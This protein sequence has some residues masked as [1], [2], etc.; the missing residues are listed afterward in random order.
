M[1]T[2][3][4]YNF[5]E[6]I[7]VQDIVTEAFWRLGIQP[8][9]L[10]PIDE[11]TAMMAANLELR[12]WSATH[13][14]FG[15]IQRDMLDL[16]PGQPF[17]TLS[18]YTNRVFEVTKANY[19][20]ILNG[21]TPIASQ[22]DATPCFTVGDT[23]GLTQTL[24]NGWIGYN[25][26][27]TAGLLPQAIWYVGVSALATTSYCLVIE[28]SYDNVTWFTQKSTPVTTYLAGIL[29]WFVCEQPLIAPYWRIRE[30][31]GNILAIQQIYFCTPNPNMSDL[32]L[33]PIP[34]D[35]FMK[36]TQKLLPNNG[37]S[38]YYFNQKKVKSLYL[39]GQNTSG[40]TSLLFS[41]EL[42]AQDI[43][44]LTQNLDLVSKFYDPLICAMALRLSLKYKPQ[45]YDVLMREYQAVVPITLASDREV[46]P[47]RLEYDME[48]TWDVFT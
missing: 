46:A 33:G 16:V 30:T 14:I 25:F 34:S 42:Y 43:S 47:V 5:A 9:T 20:R 41:S 17:Y 32:A 22:G 4:T 37:T 2:S 38:A 44:Q 21:G 35:Q 23:G 24:P 36:L 3:Q 8:Q 28:A 13:Q 26:A 45:L 10:T 19:I 1:A 27:P 39:Y 29:Q 6:S 31:K 40:F 12:K 11:Q 48:A 18:G 7:K 15:L